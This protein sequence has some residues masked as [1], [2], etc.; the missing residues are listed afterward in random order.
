MYKENYLTIY[1][2]MELE[3]AGLD[4]DELARMSWLDRFN[5]IADAGLSPV[6]YDYGF[7]DDD[8]ED[9]APAPKKKKTISESKP[10]SVI[11]TSE[12]RVRKESRRERKRRERELKRA[13]KDLADE[14]MM[15]AE[16]FADD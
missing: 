8:Y 1:D 13:I 9:A 10:V 12:R 6:D 16:V 7:L 4:V 15:F 14:I 11:D 2:E 3:E 5:A